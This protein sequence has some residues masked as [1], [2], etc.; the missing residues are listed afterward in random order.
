MKRRQ[1]Q[2][3]FF[4]VTTAIVFNVSLAT[5][6]TAPVNVRIDRYL[7]VQQMSGKVTYDRQSTS[8]PARVGDR[9]ERVGDGVTTEKA[10]SAS[11]LVDTGVGVVNVLEQTKLRVR[12]LA[13]APDK[14]RITRLDVTRGQV[15]LR[16]RPFTN[17]GSQLE[18]HTPA[19]V[20]GVRGTEFG[21]SV[22]PTGKTGLAT[23]TGAVATSAQGASV[24]VPAGFQNLT[25]PGEKPSDPVPLRDDPGLNYEFEKFIERNIRKIRLNGQ[26][27]PVNLVTV[28][29]KPVETDRQGRFSVLFF[30]PNGLRVTVVVTTPLGK[31]Q[32]YELAFR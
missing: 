11:L 26:T 14:G 16:L 21:V 4:A 19:G 2:N 29:G 8:R 5:S 13:I 3:I 6:Q 31:T 28:D 25:I 22:Q 30:A 12:D 20:S 17:R 27:D 9:L 32:T 24:D 1:L 10:S 15:R 18:I 23:L 7:A